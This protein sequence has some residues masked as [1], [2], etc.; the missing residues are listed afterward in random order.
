MSVDVNWYSCSFIGVKFFLCIGTH[1]WSFYKYKEFVI[2]PTV[3]LQKWKNIFFF[4][5]L[6]EAKN[7][8]VGTSEFNSTVFL[9]KSFLI[10]GNDPTRVIVVLLQMIRRNISWFFQ[11][12]RKTVEEIK[13][14]LVFSELYCQRLQPYSIRPFESPEVAVLFKV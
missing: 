13:L 5:F 12:E 11:I 14:F 2:Q 4:F 6:K 1:D 3:S 8:I 7:I 10:R 9:I